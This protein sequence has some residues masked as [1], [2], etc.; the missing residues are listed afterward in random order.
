[1]KDETLTGRQLDEYHLEKLLGQGGMA[2]I[3]RATD[4]RLKRK[5]AVKVI[6]PPLRGDP[7][8]AR[9]FGLEAQAVAR[10]SHPNIVPIYRFGETDGLLYMAMEYVDGTDF[11]RLLDQFSSR[12]RLL[13]HPR[14]MQVLTATA[15]ALDYAHSKQVIH[16]DVKPWNILISRENR[17]LLTDF[18]LALLAEMGT[19]GEIFGSPHYISPEQAVSSAGAVPNSDQYALGVMLFQ[20]FTGHLPFESDDPMA[21]AM[22]HVQQPPPAPGTLNPELP[23]ALDSVILRALDK[24]PDRRYPSCVEL[25]QAVERAL[26]ETLE[27]AEETRPAPPTRLRADPAITQVGRAVSS[28]SFFDDRGWLLAGLIGVS[29]IALLGFFMSQLGE[30]PAAAQSAITPFEDSAT[31]TGSVTI[32]LTP[33]STQTELPAVITAIPASTLAD[34]LPSAT[35][36]ETPVPPSATPQ[37]IWYTLQLIRTG[38][39]S[40]Y[41][42]NQSGIPFPLRT[43]TLGS[44]NGAVQGSEWGID[45]LVDGGCVSVWKS[46]GSHSPMPSGIDCVEAG[47]LERKK[48]EQFWS[49][50]FDV[51]FDGQ[52]IDTCLTDQEECSI[53]ILAA[54]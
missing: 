46:G 6:D 10:L 28:R 32:T 49:K 12:G 7:E 14:I 5:A 9:R 51:L 23:P 25:M 30:P 17:I 36:S 26:R 31:H 44:G 20:C 42:I 21:V 48:K 1:V 8:Y 33:E 18:G 35:P 41:V 45:G 54:P 16:R 53:R 3:Y 15:Q 37:G 27:L 4:V 39:D 24:D 11:G 13:D 52:K 50:T 2:R 38:G 22:A 47:R 43:L 34:V 19:R 40:L 29:L